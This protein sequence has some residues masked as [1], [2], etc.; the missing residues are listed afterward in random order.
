[1]LASMQTGSIA[2]FMFW[3]ILFYNTTQ[4]PDWR[5][6]SIAMVC[7]GVALLASVG[8]AVWLE[9]RRGKRVDEGEGREEEG[10][11]VRED[12]VVVDEDRGEK[13]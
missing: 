9:K 8:V 13:G 4:V 11:E 2:V 1:M 3:S 7:M 10:I 6:G 12:G 5:S